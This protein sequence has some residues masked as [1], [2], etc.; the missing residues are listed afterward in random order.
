MGYGKL[1][2]DD[3]VQ[4]ATVELRLLELPFDDDDPFLPSPGLM[5]PRWQGRGSLLSSLHTGKAHTLKWVNPPSS[6]EIHLSMFNC[7]SFLSLSLSLR[8]SDERLRMQ[9]QQ[10]RDALTH[11]LR[12]SH[13]RMRQEKVSPFCFVFF[14]YFTCKIL[15]TDLLFLEKERKVRKKRVVKTS[16]T[17]FSFFVVTTE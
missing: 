7:T 16:L 12:H 6:K 9:Q 11:F 2:V 17:F 1:L 15:T 3:L 8:V 5:A 10:Q 4:I 13:A 14:S